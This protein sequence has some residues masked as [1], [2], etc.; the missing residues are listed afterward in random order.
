MC[1]P[2]LKPLHP[3]SSLIRSK[4]DAFRKLTS[5]QIMDSLKPGKAQPLT[6]KADGTIIEGHHRIQVLKERQIDVDVL[7]RVQYMEEP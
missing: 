1:I 4:L 3:P 7:P 6:A 5:D 2:P